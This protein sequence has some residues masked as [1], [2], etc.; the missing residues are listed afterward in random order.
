APVRFLAANPYSRFHADSLVIEL[1]TRPGRAQATLRGA[2]LVSARVRPGGTAHVRAELERWRGARETVALDIPVP[3]ELPDG[4]YL[5]HVGGGL[6]ADRF[7]AARL[8]ARFRPVSLDDAWERLAETRRSDALH[9]GIW[10]RAP[11][12]NSD[13]D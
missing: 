7:L 13:G 11:E 1:A 12:I 4:R 6:E 10:A 3:D 2:T 8:P 9:V 5:M